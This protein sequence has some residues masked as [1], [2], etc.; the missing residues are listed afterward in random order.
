MDSTRLMKHLLNSITSKLANTLPNVSCEGAPRLFGKYVR[1]QS[2]C[3]SP[4]SCMLSNPTHP[5]I[6]ADIETNKISF[7]ECLILPL[8]II[9]GSLSAM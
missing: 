5:L 4:K 2:R 3:C 8:L 6:T 7:N 9:L 1:N